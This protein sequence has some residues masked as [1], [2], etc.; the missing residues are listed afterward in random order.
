MV[1]GTCHCGAVA[2]EVD[3]APTEV[4]SCNC[5]VCRRYGVLWAYYREAQVRV[6]GETEAY[7]WSEKIIGFNRC[8]S[9]G[10]VT[11]WKALPDRE[12]EDH[13]GV[14]ARLLDPPVLA[15]A[16]VRLLDGADT[17]RYLE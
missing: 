17:W 1:R 10:C 14:N 2:F 12:H 16:R 9:C 11:H 13:M 8:R 3:E 7:S 4:T 5:S 6:T 15:A